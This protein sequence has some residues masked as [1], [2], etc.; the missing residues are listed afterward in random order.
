MHFV[1]MKKIVIMTLGCLW[2]ISGYTWAQFCLLEED[3]KFSANSNPLIY[4]RIL[5]F[6]SFISLSYLLSTINL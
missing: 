2:K 5:L 3:L 1:C 6:Y 4:L